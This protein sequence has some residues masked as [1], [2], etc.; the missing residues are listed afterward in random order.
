MAF[1]TH[2]VV[3]SGILAGQFVQTVV[4][5]RLNN[6][7]PTD[8]YQASRDMALACVD[9]NGFVT[10]MMNSLPADYAGTSVRVKR[11]DSGGG[12]TAIVLAGAWT[13]AAGQRAGNISSAQVAPL[14]ILIGTDNP[15][16]TGRIFLPGVS[17]DDIDEMVLSA[18][19]LLEMDGLITN[20]ITPGTTPNLSIPYDGAIYRRAAPNAVPPRVES[21]DLVANGYISPK[22]GT[23]RKRLTP[24]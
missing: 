1:E 16:R 7:S 20:F 19:L 23:M 11:V 15:N 8:P 10:A 14:I 22:I 6:P 5:F 4:H 24:V 3:I 2:E 12:P 9:T 18:A 17:E 21:T 13:E